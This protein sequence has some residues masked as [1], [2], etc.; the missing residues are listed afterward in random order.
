MNNSAY[1]RFF[2][3][4]LLKPG[5]YATVQNI[6]MNTN[7]VGQ[8]AV[9]FENE[10]L[11]AVNKPAGLVVH[12]DGKTA[13]P[14][15]CDWIMEKW[16]GI[17]GVG[18]PLVLNKGQAN[19]LVIDRPGIVHRLDRDTSGVMIVAKTQESFLFL[20]EQFHER[21][22][23][24]T[25]RAV[26]WGLVKED[27]GVIDRPIGRSKTDFRKWSA[28]RFARGELRPATTEYKVLSRIE[29][30]GTVSGEKG[31]TAKKGQQNIPQNFTY[32]E[33]YP[34]TGRTHQIRVHFK[35]INHPILGDSLYAPN[36]PLAFGFL[37]TALHAFRIKVTDR[38][39]TEHEFEAGLPEDFQG[40]EASLR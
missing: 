27:K 4:R 36:H 24:K 21:E 20:K 2:Q 11:I 15:L 31:K 3:A 9:I 8:P 19:E 34:K 1:A 22:I 32:I 28:E 13:E 14:T 7:P 40:F 16:P 26:V 10:Y 38:G 12:S 5:L 25:Y 17:K 33:A 18:E 23:Q 39:G 6:Y 30:G 37:R 35:A 29:G